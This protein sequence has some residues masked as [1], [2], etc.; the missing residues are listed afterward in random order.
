MVNAV[1]VRVDRSL[2]VIVT[3]LLPFLAT[4]LPWRR[5]TGVGRRLVNIEPVSDVIWRSR[6]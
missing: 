4:L 1:A 2:T 5:R 3:P 6:L